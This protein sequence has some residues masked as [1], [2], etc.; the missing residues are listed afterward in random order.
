M[1]KSLVDYFK[2]EKN[3]GLINQLISFGL[4]TLLIGTT[5]VDPNSYFYNKTVVI[6][7]TLSLFGRNEL[8][9]L[10][11]GKGASVTT[12]VTKSTNILIAGAEAGSKLDKANKLGIEII[13]E[14]RLKELLKL[15]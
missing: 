10:L 14:D 13:N 4:N 6:T 9:A 3:I 2:D 12:S 15:N 8:T 5:E 7:G 11:E 1:V